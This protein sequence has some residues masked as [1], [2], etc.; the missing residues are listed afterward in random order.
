MSESAVE[1][2]DPQRRSY[3]L[4]T[5]HRWHWIS[6]AICLVSMLGF[7][8]TGI[9]LNHASQIS[10]RPITRTQQAEL[11]HALREALAAQATAGEDDALPVELIE[12][13]RSTLSV[14]LSGRQPEWSSDE[15]YVSLPRA[16]GDAWIAIDLANAAVEYE[17]T[18]RGWVAWFNDLHKGRNTGPAWRWF[19]D[20]FAFATLVFCLTG[21]LLLQL[22]A[23]QRGMTW[24]MVALGVLLPALF[25]LLLVH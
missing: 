8:I 19:I 1:K 21:L 14:Q 7:S 5:L 20:V 15:L 6:A 17:S 4:K 3:W 11:P 24:P 18:D 25:L 2:R 16:G 13:A 9:T 22:H 23:R 12:W 10:A